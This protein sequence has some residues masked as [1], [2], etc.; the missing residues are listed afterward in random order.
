MLPATDRE[1]GWKPLNA[2]IR[3]V[4]PIEYEIEIYSPLEGFITRIPTSLRG[5]L[6][7]EDLPREVVLLAE[8]IEVDAH[9]L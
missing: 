3:E 1:K 2:T 7:L 6:C 4:S 8:V 5:V 9:E